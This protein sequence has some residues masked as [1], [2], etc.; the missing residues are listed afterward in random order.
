MN[1]TRIFFFVL[2]LSHLYNGITKAFENNLSEEQYVDVICYK[3]EL[4]FLA[5]E[6]STYKCVRYVE[7]IETDYTGEQYY[8]HET[9]CGDF[10]HP[11]HPGK[12]IC[13]SLVPHKLFYTFALFLPW[14][15]REDIRQ[16]YINEKQAQRSYV[17][18]SMRLLF[19]SPDLL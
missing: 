3:S 1:R 10:K 17:Y 15:P 2:L 19:F 8:F 12:S 5:Q 4:V 6:I 11:M 18:L 7:T 13:Y 16:C 9:K 14:I